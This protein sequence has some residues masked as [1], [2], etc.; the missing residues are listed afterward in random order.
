M[1]SLP[2]A[3]KRTGQIIK[4]KYVHRSFMYDRVLVSFVS[5][6]PLFHLSRDA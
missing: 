6:K 5:R 1:L 4:M 3:A 2:S